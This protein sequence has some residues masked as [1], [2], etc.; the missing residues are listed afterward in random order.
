M[1]KQDSTQPEKKEFNHN[2]ASYHRPFRW[3]RDPVNDFPMA[4]F[5]ET[6]LDVCLGVGLCLELVSE[7][8]TA[9]D[10]NRDA[11]AGEEVPPS[12]DVP[13]TSRLLRLS[14]VATRM[15]ATL[16]ERRIDWI[17][18]YG[19]KYLAERRPWPAK[20]GSSAERQ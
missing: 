12:L 16:A 3:T 5:V 8:E 1:A 13:D 15:L 7:S 20:T 2:K 10:Q 4:E 19:E 18:E 9:R 11:D 14:I 17:N 6:T